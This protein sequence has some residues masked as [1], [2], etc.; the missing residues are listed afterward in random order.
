LAEA[1]AARGI[2]VQPIVYPAVEESLARLRFFIT[3]RHTEEQLRI[4]ASALVEEL[5]KLRAAG[6]RVASAGREGRRE[7]AREN[8]GGDA[9]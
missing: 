1:L 3:A 8:A 2:N 9:E 5:A 6:S 4:A 7:D